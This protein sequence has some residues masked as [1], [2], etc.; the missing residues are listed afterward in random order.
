MPAEGDEMHAPLDDTLDHRT[1]VQSSAAVLSRLREASPRVHCITNTVAQNFTAN[2]LLAIGAQPSMTVS[3]EEVAAF[4]TGADALLINLGTFDR[5][6]AWSIGLAVTAAVTAGRPWALDPVLIDRSPFRANLARDLMS[7]GPAAMRLNAAEFEALAGASATADRVTA[8]AAERV[9]A[10]TLSGAIDLIADGR[11]CVTLANG[12]PLMAR[13]T[14]MGC[15]ASAL[16][17]AC[18]A[19]EAD[20]WQA[21]LAAMTIFGIAGELAGERSQGPG[22]FAVNFIDALHQL[23]ETALIDR[24]RVS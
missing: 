15:A 24:A 12:H 6:R 14:A 4:A 16:V 21:S 18:L 17:A 9:M 13:I 19:V 8:F 10:V 7:R 20:R 3:P 5:E 22:S 23:D 2:V 11:R 1:A